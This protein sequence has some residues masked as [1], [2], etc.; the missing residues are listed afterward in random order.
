MT[1]RR[2]HALFGAPPR[3]PESPLTQFH[4]D[5]AASI[6]SVLED[7]ILRLTRSLA[8]EYAIPNLCL[9]GGVALNCVA[10][11]KILQDGAFTNLWV[12]PAAGDA[13][14]ALG[15]CLA[16]HH[17]HLSHPRTPHTPDS[18]HG[19]FL[20]PHFTQAETQNR[21]TALHAQYETLPDDALLTRTAE[22]LAAGKTIGWHQGRMEFGPRA[23]GNRSILADPRHP[24]MQEQLNHHV[25]RR[26]TFRPFAPAVLAEHAATWF[27][28]HHPSPY[29]ALVTTVNPAH[30][31]PAVTHVDGSARLQT[32]HAE[33]N[34]RFH[35]L[36]TRFH[37]LTGC[38][39]L[40]NTSFN[41]RGEPVVN[42]P[43]DA[44]RSFMDSGLD[45]LVVG[46]CWL[47]K[48]QQNPELKQKYTRAFTPD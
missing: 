21:L 24:A 19:S 42:T 35:A 5:I 28:L 4:K 17:W 27:N 20:G 43:E 11:G 30:P 34:P 37:A 14:G 47:D 6:Q 38:P 33:T 31:L 26:E 46:N 45:M 9:A 10:N 3:Q 44:F 12:Q 29:M 41:M 23:L 1:T 7:I 18:M 22:A 48:A 16:A 8:K 40:L 25:K 39:V 32:V 2:L 13:G 36:L 15:A